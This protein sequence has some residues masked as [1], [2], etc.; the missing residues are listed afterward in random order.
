MI[1]RANGSGQVEA[2]QTAGDVNFDRQGS[3]ADLLT[4]EGK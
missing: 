3:P 1:L 4:G 2:A